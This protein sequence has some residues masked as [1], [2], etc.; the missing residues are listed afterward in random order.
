MGLL[1]TKKGDYYIEP[2]KRH[3]ASRTGH[4]HVVFQRSAL[5]NKVINHGY[6]DANGAELA[7]FKK[8]SFLSSEILFVRSI[9]IVI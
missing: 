5:K 9:Q 6:L 7:I 1:K 3:T 4:P 8:C 2:S